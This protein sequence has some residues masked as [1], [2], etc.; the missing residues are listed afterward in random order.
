MEMRNKPKISFSPPL[1]V[2]GLWAELLCGIIGS[3]VLAMA[4]SRFQMIGAQMQ[5]VLLPE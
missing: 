4:W 3:F 1:K 2:R 5:H